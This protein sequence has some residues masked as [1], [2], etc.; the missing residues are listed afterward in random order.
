MD[1]EQLGIATETTHKMDLL[2]LF[3]Q[4]SLGLPANTPPPSYPSGMLNS[5]WH[6]Q[7][8]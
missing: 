2:T 5:I 3:P 8:N 4:S 1:E 7:N 6:L